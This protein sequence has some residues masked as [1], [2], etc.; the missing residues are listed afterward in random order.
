MDMLGQ[1]PADAE[2]N[3]LPFSPAVAIPGLVFLSGQVPLRD[4]RIEGHDIGSQ[5]DCVLDN[6]EAALSLA[7]CTLDH[8][9]K[10]TVWLVERSDF[11]AFNYA[12][13]RRFGNH[14]PARST[15]VSALALKG[16]LVEIEAI[17]V[18]PI[19]DLRSL[20]KA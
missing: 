7:G 17:A 18:P 15:L 6:M 9:I 16:A 20:S 14:R 13:A 19:T 10:T 1:P 11:A 5:T 3:A 4:G 2:G 12:Y 8:V